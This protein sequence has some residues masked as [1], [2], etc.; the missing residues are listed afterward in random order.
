M[1]T[2][3]FLDH[4]FRYFNISFYVISLCFPHVT[5]SFIPVFLAILLAILQCNL[6]VSSSQ[7]PRSGWKW[8]FG[9]QREHAGNGSRQCKDPGG[10]AEVGFSHVSTLL[11]LI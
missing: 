6:K 11:D 7:N 9:F 2:V 8:L 1:G 5:F 10:Q 4:I 3:H